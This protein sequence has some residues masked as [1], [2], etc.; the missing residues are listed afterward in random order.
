MTNLHDKVVVITEAAQGQGAACTAAGATV[1]G[2]DLREAD[3]VRAHDV[4]SEKDWAALREDLVAEH[5]TVHGLVNNAG[6]THRARLLEL[7]VADLERVLAVNLTGPLLAIPVDGGQTA[8]G[9]AKA[10]SDALRAPTHEG[11]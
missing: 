7:H 6:I 2:L 5:G 9:G 4:A 8:H 10:I 11:Q 3:G 1:I